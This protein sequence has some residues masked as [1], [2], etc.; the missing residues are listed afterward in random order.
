MSYH[1]S[2]WVLCETAQTSQNALQLNSSP[3]LQRPPLSW[4]SCYIPPC[5]VSHIYSVA[6]RLCL[7]TIPGKNRIGW[8][9][10]VT[11][12]GKC[13]LGLSL[14]QP[15]YSEPPLQFSKDSTCWTLITKSLW[16]LYTWLLAFSGNNRFTAMSLLCAVLYAVQSFF[17][18][19][20]FSHSAVW[21]TTY[22]S[23]SE[24]CLP[25]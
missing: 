3:E 1:H 18:V 11:F 10:I 25:I 16:L 15:I 13:V 8:W 4:G 22:Q 5:R 17:F 7:A 24:A 6:A 20:Y 23:H 9:S 12:D 19:R 21:E 14:Q 2:F